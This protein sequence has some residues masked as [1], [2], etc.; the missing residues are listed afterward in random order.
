[1][2]F[3]LASQLVLWKVA[4]L[5]LPS[6]IRSDLGNQASLHRLGKSLRK[7]QHTPLLI[8]ADGTVVD[9]FRRVTAA[10]LEGIESLYC[11]VVDASITPG[12]RR[13]IQWC[14]AIHRE[15]ISPYD[16]AVTIRDIKADYP[17]LSNRQLAEDILDIDHT[18]ITQY[19]SLFQRCS[20]E[21]Q[22][23]AKAGRIGL[24]DWYTIAKSPDQKATL[25]L[26][27]DR[28]IPSDS[29]NETQ[30]GDG[31]TEF[32]TSHSTELPPAP[33][34]A[35][36]GSTHNDKPRHRNGNG[37]GQQTPRPTRIPIPLAT[38][39]ATGTVIAVGED[40]DLEA[41]ETLLKEAVKAVRLPRIKLSNA[42]G[43]VALTVGGDD[44][45]PDEAEALLKEAIK[46]VQAAI[47]DGNTL[48]TAQ[49]R[50]RDKT[51]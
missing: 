6:N 39:T 21:V 43:V 41:T 13:Q 33:D 26:I 20:P 2:G 3:T 8:L 50:W 38:D 11:V 17:N 28:S 24:N 45:D 32:P 34:S 1:M 15:A 16:T 19:L 27:V 31:G 48:K 42:M 4:D 36:N 23:A 10:L 37:N 25:G 47:K 18:S 7:G 30:N 46:A 44:S 14:C 5:K 51:K 40:L 9:G 29:E 22:E 12:E 35:L 49:S